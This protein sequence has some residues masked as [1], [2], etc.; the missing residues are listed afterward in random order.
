MSTDALNEAIEAAIA[1]DPHRILGATT[2][3]VPIDEVAPQM[4][5][6][7]LRIERLLEQQMEILGEMASSPTDPPRRRGRPP[8]ES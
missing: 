6:A 3:F 8:K 7:L 2:P 1:R 5:A 4:L